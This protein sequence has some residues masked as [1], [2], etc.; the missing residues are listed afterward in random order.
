MK[1]T[2][3]F[4]GGFVAGILATYL[5]AFVLT[6]QSESND[7]LSG[8]TMFPEKGEF[9]TKSDL[10]IFQ[11]LKPNMALAKFGKYLDETLVLLINE[12]NIFYYDDQIVKIPPKKC[13]RLI[14]TFQYETK[15]EMPK[16]VPV[17]VIE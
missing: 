1:Q 16:T 11:T 12:E 2:L 14:G 9:L 15:A 5:V 7:D 8:L 10:K 6:N 13:A 17:V 4:V 3:I